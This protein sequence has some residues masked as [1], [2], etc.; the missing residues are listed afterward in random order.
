M[1]S[2]TG[3]VNAIALDKCSKSGLVFDVSAKFFTLHSHSCTT[4]APL[5]S[6][7]FFMQGLRLTFIV[8]VPPSCSKCRCSTKFWSSKVRIL[9]ATMYLVIESDVPCVSKGF[10]R[11]LQYYNM[12]IAWHW[13]NFMHTGCPFSLWNC[14]LHECW[15]AMPS[16]LLKHF[17][18]L[19][20]HAWARSL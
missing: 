17:Y 2:I 18:E 10:N 20:C 12:D 8:K 19:Y 3:K 4:L 15:G 16:K 5:Q 1:P 9:Q 13:S 14:E 7:A 11:I 6:H